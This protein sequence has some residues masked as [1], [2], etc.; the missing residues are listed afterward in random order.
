MNIAEMTKEELETE[1]V[2]NN[3]GLYEMFNEEKLLNKEYTLEE[4][5]EITANWIIEGNEA[6]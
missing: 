2:C 4:L 6:Y 1:I 5:Q 3:E